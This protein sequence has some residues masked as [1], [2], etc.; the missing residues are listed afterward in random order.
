MENRVLKALINIKTNLTVL[1]L[2]F[3]KVHKNLFDLKF[4]TKE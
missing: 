1:R 4:P 2:L 3:E